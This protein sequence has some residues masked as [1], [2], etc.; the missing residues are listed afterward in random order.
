ML[1]IMQ[2]RELSWL[3][4]NER[5]LEEAECADTPLLDRFSFLSIFTTN[6]DEFFMVRVGALSDYLSFVPGYL[7]DKTGMTAKEELHEICRAVRL[8]YEKRD[9]GYCELSGL[10][11]RENVVRL[12][13]EQLHKNDWKKAEKYFRYSV[14]PLL[15]PQIIDPRHPFP[16]LNNKQLYIAVSLKKGNRRVFGLIPVPTGMERLFFT[17][18]SRQRF[19]LAEDILLHYADEVFEHYTIEC[20]A[21]ISVTRSADIDPDSDELDND[22]DYRQHMKKILKKRQRLFPV[23]LELQG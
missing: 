1:T 22:G 18:T 23:R 7:D 12:H 13:T 14:K 3:K 16:H 2:N 8:L 17:D 21:V 19:L 20:K 15:S 4:F 6:L 9:Q 10:L 11:E 5:V